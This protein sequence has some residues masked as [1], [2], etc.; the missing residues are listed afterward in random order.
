[1]I[2]ST[3]NRTL[4]DTCSIVVN[5]EPI[6]V[7]LS[8]TIVLQFEFENTTDKKQNLNL[9]VVDGILV[10][11]L[12]NFNNPLGTAPA[13]PIEIGTYQNQPLFVHFSIHTMGDKAKLLTCSFWKGEQNE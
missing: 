6:R 9:E 2:V 4:I 8:P 5:N 3:G 1:M 11:R 12:Q 13:E 10:V 7:E